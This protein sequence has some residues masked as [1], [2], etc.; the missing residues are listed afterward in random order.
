MCQSAESSGD[1]PRGEMVDTGVRTQV[2]RP[3]DLLMQ[4]LG[5]H[6]LVSLLMIMN[7]LDI[8]QPFMAAV[9]TSI[10]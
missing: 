6:E 10:S 8:D 3:L 5:N 2:K 1:K 4:E 9:L 7:A